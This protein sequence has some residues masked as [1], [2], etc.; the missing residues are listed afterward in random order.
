M[1]LAA[2]KEL[3]RTKSWKNE[4]T[5]VTVN[6][7]VYASIVKKAQIEVRLVVDT[8][9]TECELYILPPPPNNVTHNTKK[10]HLRFRCSSSENGNESND[11]EE[12]PC[13]AAN[14]CRVV[15][16][17]KAWDIQ[18]NEEDSDEKA[19]NNNKTALLMMVDGMDYL[20][21]PEIWQATLN[22]AS[23]AHR[24]GREL[25]LWIGNI[26]QSELHKRNTETLGPAFGFRC[27][28]KTLNNTIHYFKP[29][30]LM[31]LLE[32]FPSTHS[33]LFLDADT[34]FCKRSFD[35]LD[36]F[37]PETYLEISP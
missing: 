13:R 18:P 29:L 30:A 11:L 22:K 1:W 14:L 3:R 35:H 6:R 21:R 32:T 34:A 12:T 16:D 9:F 7:T 20:T 28:E 8:V 26:D 25:F 2:S 33:V 19:G 5:F 27:I 31:A 17:P 10:P 15:V 4:S 23:Y 37:G 36:E 24:S